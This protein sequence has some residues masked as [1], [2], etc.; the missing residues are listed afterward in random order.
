MKTDRCRCGNAIVPLGLDWIHVGLFHGPCRKAE[1]PSMFTTI[2]MDN[3]VDAWHDIERTA[4][5]M[6]NRKGTTS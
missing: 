4:M 5:A 2:T 6:R 3:F 1:P